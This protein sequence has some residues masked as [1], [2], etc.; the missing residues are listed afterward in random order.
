MTRH[1]EQRAALIRER[2]GRLA[3]YRAAVAARDAIAPHAASPYAIDFGRRA[4]A[5]AEARVE[6]ALTNMR[7]WRDPLPE[8][9]AAHPSTTFTSAAGTDALS[10]PAAG[11]ETELEAVVAWILR[12]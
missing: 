6:L 8:S 5:R 10:P 9:G 2:D 1:E 4:L 12:A 3:T 7:H 11:V